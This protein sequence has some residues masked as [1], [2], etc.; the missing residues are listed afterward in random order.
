MVCRRY[1]FTIISYLFEIF[2]PTYDHDLYSRKFA[3]LL[4]TA[5]KR[6]SGDPVKALNWLDKKYKAYIVLIFSRRRVENTDAFL[7]V[8]EHIL[9]R[10]EIQE[11]GEK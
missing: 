10:I 11:K 2:M 8:R 7:D 5:I 1:N 3:R 4:N 9:K 6:G